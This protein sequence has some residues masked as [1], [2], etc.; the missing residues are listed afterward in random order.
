MKS[1]TEDSL[2]YSESKG[3]RKNGK[4]SDNK[5]DMHKKVPGLSEVILATRV[6]NCV[7]SNNHNRSP[8]LQS[9]L[10]TVRN[11]SSKS[12]TDPKKPKR[13][14]GR[15]HGSLTNMT[16]AKLERKAKLSRLANNFELK[17]PK[18]GPKYHEVSRKVLKNR[19]N[20]G[21]RHILVRLSKPLVQMVKSFNVI[22]AQNSIR[23]VKWSVFILKSIT[24]IWPLQN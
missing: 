14:P 7:I 2:G 10:N 21:F 8:K 16:Q 23:F 18:G 9:R 6:N 1:E 4:E 15:P 3:T 11:A 20:M 12:K 19:P 17:N 24:T 5:S 22:I 13:P